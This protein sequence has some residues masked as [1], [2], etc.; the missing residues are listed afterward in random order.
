MIRKKKKISLYGFDAL[1]LGI[2]GILNPETKLHLNGH[3]SL[4]SD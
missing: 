2:K 1:R 3:L 4:S